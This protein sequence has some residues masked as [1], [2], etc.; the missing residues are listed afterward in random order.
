MTNPLYGSDSAPVERTVTTMQP[1][2]APAGL[3]RRT[4]YEEIL[5]VLSLSLL[6][7]AAYAIISLLSAPLKGGYVASANQTN[8]LA[9]QLVSLA[10]SLAP[11]LAGGPSAPPER[12]GRRGDRAGVGPTGARHQARRRVLR[13]RRAR[14]AGVLLRSG[15]ARREPVRRPGAAARPLVDR[16]DPG[17]E[18]RAGRAPRRG[19]RPRVPDH[20][21]A[22]ARVEPVRG[23]RRQARC[24]AARITCIRG[25]EGSRATWRWASCSASRSFACAGRGRSSIAHFLLDVAAGVGF[26]LF[27]EHLPGFS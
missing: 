5:I 10:F 8:V 22:S 2:T 13:G 18:R 25:G 24:S 14:R 7:S 23:G 12:R 11:G 3:D 26:I 1:P 27:R 15:R 20:P 4:L 9:R 21:A 6:A 16:A 17:A 19:D